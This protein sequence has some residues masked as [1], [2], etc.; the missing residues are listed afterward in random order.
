VAP[1][2]QALAGGVVYQASPLVDPL[3]RSGVPTVGE[4]TSQV[5]QAQLPVVGGVDQLTQSLPVDSALVGEP[6]TGAL[7]NLSTL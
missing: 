5:G 3:R 6:L 1:Q 7:R 4:L 2:A